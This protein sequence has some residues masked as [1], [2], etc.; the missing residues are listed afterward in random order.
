MLKLEIKRRG[1]SS[2]LATVFRRV[3]FRTIVLNG[4][5]ITDGQLALGIAPGTNW[6]FEIN[7]HEFFAKGSNFIPPG[8]SAVDCSSEGLE[9]R[10]HSM[11]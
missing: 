7:G 10:A 5:A 6:H 9:G 4:E 3:G 8:M 1:S 2:S 11:L